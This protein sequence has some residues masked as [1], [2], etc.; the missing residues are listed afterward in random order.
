MKLISVK[1]MLVILWIHCV[2]ILL[3]KIIAFLDN[4]RSFFIEINRKSW[5]VNKQKRLSNNMATMK[6]ITHSP[7]Y[8]KKIPNHFIESLYSLIEVRDY[9]WFYLRLI[10]IF[11]TKSQQYS[12][13]IDWAENKRSFT[14][15]KPNMFAEIV[16]PIL[17]KHHKLSSFVRQVTTKINWNN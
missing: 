17:C 8:P 2:D 16:L 6:G 1:I 9:D 4:K 14:I 15:Y 7:D 3:R 12:E 11:F 10:L 13:L 5:T